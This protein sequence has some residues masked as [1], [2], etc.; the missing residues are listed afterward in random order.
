MADAGLGVAQFFG[1]FCQALQ[2]NGL[3]KGIILKD[4]QIDFHPIQ[5]CYVIHNIYSIALCVLTIYNNSIK[6]ASGFSQ[7]IQKNSDI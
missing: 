3:E 6:F 7:K 1:C 2:L 5:L 4:T